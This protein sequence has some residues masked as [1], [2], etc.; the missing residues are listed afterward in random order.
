MDHSIVHPVLHEHETKNVFACHLKILGCI[1][2]FEVLFGGYRQVATALYFVQMIFDK[3]NKHRLYSVSVH[4]QSVFN[5]LKLVSNQIETHS[6]SNEWDILVN[7]FDRYVMPKIDWV[8][9]RM[10]SST[11]AC[12]CKHM[13]GILIRDME[14]RINC[15]R[16]FRW[17]FI[18]GNFV[19][20]QQLPKSMC[21]ID[22]F[23]RKGSVLC[24]AIERKCICWFPI[25]D[26]I[27]FEPF[28][29]GFN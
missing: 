21:F 8:W 13:I 10:Y 24:I 7:V 29:C 19:W 18:A 11:I 22:D 2:S 26:F 15:K 28:D 16:I 20:N 14:R 6:D 25:W 9:R 12:Q 23:S 4:N 5:Q 1:F 27:Y 3:I 17:D